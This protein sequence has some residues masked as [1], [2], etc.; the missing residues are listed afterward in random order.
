MRLLCQAGREGAFRAEESGHDCR[1]I[2]AVLFARGIKDDSLAELLYVLV[3]IF[4]YAPGLHPPFL[5]IF[6]QVDQLSLPS[7]ELNELVSCRQPSE[8]FDVCRIVLGQ[9]EARSNLASESDAVTRRTRGVFIIG[10][11]CAE[12]IPPSSIP[13]S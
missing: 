1:G 8:A 10:R 5:C 7:I 2:N 13:G 9:L 4:W 11:L 6:M 12:R 3:E